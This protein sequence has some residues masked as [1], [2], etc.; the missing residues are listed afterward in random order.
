MKF[1]LMLLISNSISVNLSDFCFGDQIRKVVESCLLCLKVR[2]LVRIFS[3]Q[4]CVYNAF[5][6]YCIGVVGIVVLHLHRNKNTKQKLQERTDKSR[7]A[8]DDL[9]LKVDHKLNI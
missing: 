9:A 7:W 2:L 5:C 3:F 4:F 1:A 8:S 6:L